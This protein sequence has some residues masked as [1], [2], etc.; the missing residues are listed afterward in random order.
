MLQVEVATVTQAG[1]QTGVHGLPPQQ[2]SV[3]NWI[4]PFIAVKLAT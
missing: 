2:F 3:R 1:V 4:N